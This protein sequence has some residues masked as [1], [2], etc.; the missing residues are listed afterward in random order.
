MKL[1]FSTY[2]SISFQKLKC[3]NGLVPSKKSTKPIFVMISRL[4]TRLTLLFAAFALLVVVSV[5]VTYLGL[6]TQRQ[7][8]LIINLAGRQ[9]MLVQQMTRLALR[10]QNG[11]VSTLA[12]LQ[13]SEQ[14]FSQT[15]SALQEGGAAPY[16]ENNTV[17]LKYTRDP[18]LQAALNDVDAAWSQYRSTLENITSSGDSASLQNLRSSLELQS[19]NLVQKADGVVRLYESTSTH[20]V[21]RLRTIQVAFL[22][23]AL[24]LL[25]V[26]A[27][28][29]RQSLL[30]PLQE[31]RLAAESLGKND[32]DT[33]VKVEGPE[34]VQALSHTFDEMRSRLRSAREELV[35]WNVTLEQRVS[36]RTHE[37]EALNEVSREISSRLE[38]QQV[39][40]SVTEKAR[41]LLGGEVA[42]LC[43]L[44]ESKHWLIL[45]TISGPDEAMIG[46]AVAVSNS[47]TDAILQGD[48][49]L[50]CGI[51]ACQGGCAIIA[52]TYRVS[53]LA[54][55]LRVGEQVIGAL[56]VGSPTLN[57][58]GNETTNI[59]TKLANV[60]AVALENA[61]LYSQAER[62]ATLEE[63]NR[64]AAEM[65][66]G[67]G[68]TLSYLGLMTDQVVNFLSE[69]QSEEA[70]ERLQKAREKIN[71]A[72]TDLRLAINQLLDESPVNQDLSICLEESVK[73]FGLQHQL[74]IEWCNRLTSATQCSR[75]VAEQVTKII[76][77]AMTNIMRHAE[78]KHVVV[79]MDKNEDVFQV[80]VKDDGR[81]FFVPSAKRNGHYGLKV[82]EVRATHIDGNVLVE[83]EPGTGTQVTLTWPVEQKG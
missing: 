36:Q 69:G 56:C 45:Q 74:P 73:K 66:D 30:Q 11:D 41:S 15:L 83:S 79:T 46:E 31:L 5:G 23:C 72:V 43:L 80:V 42:S 37:L 63:R 82:M 49:A 24:V 81:G 20:K 70:F 14:T 3:Y 60:A 29:T 4:Q 64:I 22:A 40:S 58:F 77:E 13:E 19:D 25:A 2:F 17:S 65:H 62:V 8:A 54:A 55:P 39:L 59:L 53:H 50:H 1:I 21:N 12:A 75:D 48:R 47:P 78:A 26:G 67:V 68:Q 6:Q 44:D 38:I 51:G 7:D 16:L 57:H 18:Q 71:Q 52:E 9:R 27:W 32:L 35:Q 33:P 34:E 28:I 61:R 76:I 10:L